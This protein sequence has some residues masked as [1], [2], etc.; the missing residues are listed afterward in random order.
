MRVRTREETTIRIENVGNTA[1]PH[2]EIQWRDGTGENVKAQ[3]ESLPVITEP[4][5][6]GAVVDVTVTYAPITAVSAGGQSHRGTVRFSHPDINEQVRCP[7]PQ[8]VSLVGTSYEGQTQPPDAGVT[9]AGSSPDV[10]DTGF[11]DAGRPDYGPPVRPD[12]GFP[13]WSDGHFKAAYAGSKRAGGAAIRTRRWAHGPRRR[14][15]PARRCGQHDRG[16]RPEKWRADLA[17]SDGDRADSSSP[18]ALTRW[19]GPDYGWTGQRARRPRLG[20]HIVEIFNPDDGTIAPAGAMNIGR[21]GHTASR[22]GAN[23][24]IL[25]GLTR[26]PGQAPG[27]PYSEEPAVAV[28]G[29]LAQAWVRSVAWRSRAPR[30]GSTPPRCCRETRCSCSVGWA[31]KASETTVNSSRVRRWFRSRP[32]SETLA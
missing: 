16:V 25:G 13:F 6:T 9:D 30:A 26:T 17:R 27:E 8:D 28:E 10:R 2:L 3:F 31:M 1:L 5:G 12:G 14:C 7:P 23:V 19:D 20:E 32:R 22:V 21:Y 15:E 24:V 29:C 18:C 4:I 11:H